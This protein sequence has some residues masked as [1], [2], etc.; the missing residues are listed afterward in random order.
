MTF[1]S[2][3]YRVLS[4]VLAQARAEAD[5]ITQRALS[6]RLKRPHTYIAKI[7]SGERRLDVVEFIEVARAL[8]V[9]PVKL[10]ARLIE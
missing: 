3:G 6:E 7:E 5:E 2:R 8:R 4:E 1:R 9:D 10:F